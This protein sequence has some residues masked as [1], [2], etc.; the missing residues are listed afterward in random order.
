MPPCAVVIAA[1]IR[2]VDIGELR[3]LW[4]VRRWDFVLAVVT[5]AGVVRDLM[6]RTGLEDRIGAQNFHLTVAEAVSTQT[7]SG[8]PFGAYRLG[9]SVRRI[10]GG[11]LGVAGG[12][13]GGGAAAAGADQDLQDGQEQDHE[14]QGPDQPGE[15]DVVAPEQDDGTEHADDHP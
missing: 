6:R 10:V 9:D 2:L 7:G 13:A 11:R 1:A 12:G 4:R 15:R 14:Q 3:R 8:S 5:L